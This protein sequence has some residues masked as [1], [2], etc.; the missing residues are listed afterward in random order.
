MSVTTTTNDFRSISQAHN[1]KHKRL[2][3]WAYY[4]YSHREEDYFG[5]G[6]S[7]PDILYKYD[8]KEGDK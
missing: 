2:A 8:L 7:V 3:L 6:I 5:A 1:A 4:L